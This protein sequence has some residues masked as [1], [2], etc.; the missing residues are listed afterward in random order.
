VSGASQPL[1]LL[2]GV[3]NR[4]LALDPELAEGLGELEGALL[5]VELAGTGL[6]FHAELARGRVSLTRMPPRAPDTVIRGTP[7]ALARALGAGTPA[8]GL[9]AGVSVS[10]DV[11]LAQALRRTLAC[12]GIDWEE[13]AA[14]V[15]G[16]AAAHGF[17]NWARGAR[18]FGARVAATLAEDTGEYLREEASLVADA[19]TVETFA[20]EVDRLRDDVERLERRIERLVER[21]ERQR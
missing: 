9:D 8:P 5:A 7:L 18:A 13:V 4:Y 11:E 14:A 6:T 17:G 16:D 21:G 12:L 10:G 15:V 19:P 2:E 1:A 3:V 20:A